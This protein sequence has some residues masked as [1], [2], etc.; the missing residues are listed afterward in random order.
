M[1]YICHKYSN[2]FAKTMGYIKKTRGYFGQKLRD[3][4]G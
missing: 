4:L 1:G 3:I 2:I